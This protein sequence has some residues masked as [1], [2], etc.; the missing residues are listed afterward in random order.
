MTLIDRQKVR[1]SFSRQAAEYDE[2]ARVQQRVIDRFRQQYL[3]GAAAPG[4]VLDIGCG[5]GR[6]LA[7]LRQDF[8]DALLCGV[9]LAFGMAAQS[10]QRLADRD[11][12]LCVCAPAERLPFPDASFDLVISTSTYQWVEALAPA[13]A[14]VKRVLKPGGR[15]CLALF[16]ERTLIELRESYRHALAV[17]G[18]D[19]PDRSHRFA[20]VAELAAALDMAGFTG[21]AAA[22]ETE[23]EQH[24]DV[25]E[26]LRSLKKIGAG[27]AS[28][29]PGGGLTG[30]RFML[31]MTEYYRRC[32]GGAGGITATYEVLYGSGVKG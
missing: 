11:N 7:V 21:V 4:F 31:A 17:T 2:A 1:Q 15:F 8:P 6:L 32:Y 29:L 24:R 16:G 14:E 12:S 10:R 13:F 22:S 25:P 3:A 27:N 5:T 26:L 30:R 28:V 23:I 20:T 19:R 9:D 18:S